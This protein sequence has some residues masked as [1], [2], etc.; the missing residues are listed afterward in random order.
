MELRRDIRSPGKWYYEAGDQLR[1]SIQGFRL[2]HCMLKYAFTTKNQRSIL[3]EDPT[4][5]TDNIQSSVQFLL[6]S[7]FMCEGSGRSLSMFKVQLLTLNKMMAF[8]CLC[9]VFFLLI[10]C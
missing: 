10:I 7:A 4:E 8:S 1:N 3:Q 2:D 5:Q 9:P 6:H